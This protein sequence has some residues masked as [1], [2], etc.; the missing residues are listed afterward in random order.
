M[1]KKK[2]PLSRVTRP[3]SSRRSSAPM[4]TTPQWLNFLQTNWLVVTIIIGASLLRFWNIPAQAIFIGETA[5][6]TLLAW[7]AVE[8][9]QL[10]LVGTESSWPG[11]YQGPVNVWLQMAVLLGSG[12]QLEI[13]FW[14][15]AL[16]SVLA[17][18]G[19]YEFTTVTVSRRA[20]L[21]AATILAFSPL[22]VAHGRMMASA[23]LIPAATL[24]FLWSLLRITSS[25]PRSMLW[26]TLAWALLFQLELSALLLIVLIP[27]VWKWQHA[28]VTHHRPLPWVPVTAGLGIG[29]LP[30]LLFEL[31]HSFSQ[32]QAVGSGFITRLSPTV[33]ISNA[34]TFV[35]HFWIRGGRIWSMD[36]W[37]VTLLGLLVV[38]G[39]VAVLMGVWR[40]HQATLLEK[41]LVAGLGLLG[42]TA[43]LSGLPS[44]GILATT[45]IFIALITALSWTRLLSIWRTVGVVVLIGWAI[46]SALLVNHCAFF[47][48]SACSFTYGASLLEQRHIVSFLK[49][50]NLASVE[51]ASSHNTTSRSLDNWRLLG[52]EVG[53]QDESQSVQPVYIEAKDSPLKSYPGMTKFSFTTQDIYVLH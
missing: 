1:P 44:D 18:V 34:I 45:I 52:Y 3:T 42:F 31:T 24:L 7:Q 49:E 15:F 35:T 25:R 19:V 29:L 30:Q 8:T 47:T 17:V 40:R 13:L 37:L 12:G 6:E 10:L 11:V 5:H 26:A 46:G 9:K 38:T 43:L 22:A 21:V 14:L 50:K 51:F 32:L 20:G 41:T 39:G 33:L 27:L 16:V 28:D 4:S 53:L 48:G 2:R 36:Y 23:A